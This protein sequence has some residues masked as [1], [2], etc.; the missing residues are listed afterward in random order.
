MRARNHAKQHAKSKRPKAIKSRKETR[1]LTLRQGFEVK[2]T[3][4]R[5][6]L[7]HGFGV[8]GANG[9][10]IDCRGIEV[11]YEDLQIGT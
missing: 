8:L 6:L 7:Q 1:K 2:T 5:P 3:F 11:K 4:H 9:D 10:P